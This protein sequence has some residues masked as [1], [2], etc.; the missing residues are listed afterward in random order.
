MNVQL[1]AAASLERTDAVARKVDGIVS[2][3][4]GVKDVTTVAGFS[5]LTRVSTT[6]SAFYFVTLKPW[7]ERSAAGLDSGAILAK[8]NGQLHAQVPEAVAFAFSPP[9]IPGLGNSVGFSLAAGPQRRHG[10]GS[11]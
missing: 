11:R 5:L 3:T 6:N 4:P 7:D 2:K 8:I 9:A 1:P 10:G